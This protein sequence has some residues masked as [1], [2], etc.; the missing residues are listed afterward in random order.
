MVFDR[1]ENAAAYYGLGSYFETALHYLAETD[2]TRMEPGKYDIDGDNVYAFV[3][4]YAT[5]PAEENN[6][7]GHEQYADIQFLASGREKMGYSPIHAAVPTGERIPEADLIFYRP[8]NQF[9]NME[10]N[11]FAIFWPQDI[12]EPKCLWGEPADVL[13][14]VVKVKVP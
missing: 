8:L 13:K 14:I 7:E 3:Q 11:M 2:F 1:L 5:V 12:H 9:L 4:K 10:P 6:A